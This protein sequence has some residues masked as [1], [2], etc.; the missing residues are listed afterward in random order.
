MKIEDTASSDFGDVTLR[1][2][3][4]PDRFEIEIQ[5]GGHDYSCR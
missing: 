4:S 2:D 3:S 1:Y 5:Q